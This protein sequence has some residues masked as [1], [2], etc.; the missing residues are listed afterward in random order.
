MVACHL[1]EAAGEVA[2]SLSFVLYADAYDSMRLL[3]GEQKGQLLDAIFI[4][5]R[6]ECM[7]TLDPVVAM[8]FSFIQ[9][10]MDRENDKYLKRCE[11]AS[12]SARMRWDANACE[13]M[14]THA[15]GC[16]T[17]PSPVPVPSPVL[18]DS[19][20]KKLPSAVKTKKEKQDRPNQCPP[21]KWEKYV[22]FSRKFHE[23]RSAVLGAIAPFTKKKVIDGAR[24]L[25][26]LVRIR[27]IDS[28]EIQAVLAWAITDSFW[29]DNVRS[30][31]SL[32]KIGSN[33]ETKYANVLASMRR[34]VA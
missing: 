7:P 29:C 1:R 24:A 13:C 22:S 18:E 28:Q 3:T 25:D 32:T 27:G 16:Y 31:A 11:K 17:V 30:L 19:E 26:A 4:Y 15:N 5:Q 20:D 8:A 9:R 34:D 33:G 21:E 23:D 2:V 6:G 12:K 14:Q 10:T